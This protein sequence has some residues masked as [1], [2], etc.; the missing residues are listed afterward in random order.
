MLTTFYEIKPFVGGQVMLA[1]FFCF[2][3]LWIIIALVQK[4]SIMIAFFSSLAAL[5]FILLY[6]SIQSR[7]EA[8]DKVERG[9]GVIYYEGVFR[10]S[11]EAVCIRKGWENASRCGSTAYSSYINNEFIALFPRP[12]LVAVEDYCYEAEK[13]KLQALNGTLV[14]FTGKWDKAEKI[15]IPDLKEKYHNKFCIYKIE[16]LASS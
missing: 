12:N 11:D 13:R 7:I 5:F 1:A 2:M 9:E 14:K 8:K 15:N 4:A 6:T 10:F 16:V 3:C